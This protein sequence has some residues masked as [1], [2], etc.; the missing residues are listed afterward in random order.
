VGGAGA[1]GLVVLDRWRTRA[2]LAGCALSCVAAVGGC[3]GDSQG[4]AAVTSPALRPTG[5]TAQLVRYHCVA[6]RRG[7][8]TVS[9]P[10]ARRLAEV[11]NPIDVCELD[12]G[13]ADVTVA[14]RCTDG[15]PS[16]D[17]HLVAHD[18]KLPAAAVREACA[19]G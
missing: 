11:L 4:P 12:G 15:S 17:V 1:Y 14:L 16:P 5:A 10:D 18:G 9:L 6:G 8:I 13:L 3:G 7:E 19:K 2:A